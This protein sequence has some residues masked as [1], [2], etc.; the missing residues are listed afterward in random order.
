MGDTICL[1]FKW[2]LIDKI[3]KIG[4]NC[5]FILNYKSFHQ[6]DKLKESEKSKLMIITISLKL[7]QLLL[8]MLEDS[9]TSIFHDTMAAELMSC[10]N[11]WHSANV[12]KCKALPKYHAY[13]KQSFQ[14]LFV[15][16]VSE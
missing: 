1:Q 8:Y 6:R 10:M 13:A 3:C 2:E 7:I 14:D 5:N 15:I 4:A 11:S 12:N 9:W 16:N